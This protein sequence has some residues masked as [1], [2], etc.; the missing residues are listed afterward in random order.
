MSMP[1]DAAEVV[2]ELMEMLQAYGIFLSDVDL[3]TDLA[4]SSLASVLMRYYK[5][6]DETSLIKK[7]QARKAENMLA[8]VSKK[9]KELK[10]LEND[11]IV[12]PI[13]RIV[14]LVEGD[15]HPHVE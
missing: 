15:V 5:C 8:F 3:E 6:N 2:K 9:I 11:K 14:E 12:N 7:M 10:A 13:K 1:K 4:K